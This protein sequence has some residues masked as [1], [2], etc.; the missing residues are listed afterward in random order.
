MDQRHLHSAS[1]FN[2]RLPHA[3]S[4]APSSHHHPLVS[5]PTHQQYLQP[6]Q[7][8]RPY[9][10]SQDQVRIPNYQHWSHNHPQRSNAMIGS[11]TQRSAPAMGIGNYNNRNHLSVPLLP[12]ED[13]ISLDDQPVIPSC[14][15]MPFQ[16]MQ[17]LPQPLN[18][19]GRPAVIGQYTTPSYLDNVQ[20]GGNLQCRMDNT[21]HH[22]RQPQIL[23]QYG[24]FGSTPGYQNPGMKQAGAYHNFVFPQQTNNSGYIG[25]QTPHFPVPFQQAPRPRGLFNF[26]TPADDT[27]RPV[28]NLGPFQHGMVNNRSG[29]ASCTSNIRSNTLAQNTG[30]RVNLP[31]NAKPF[32]VFEKEGASKTVSIPVVPVA[33]SPGTKTAVDAGQIKQV[34]NPVVPPIKLETNPQHSA[35]ERI[36]KQQIAKV[37]SLPTCPWSQLEQRKGKLGH[38][39]VT[40]KRS[41]KNRQANSWSRNVPTVRNNPPKDSGKLPEKIPPHNV[42]A[43]SQTAKRIIRKVLFNDRAG[44]VKQG[45]D[46][47]VARNKSP[48]IV[49]SQAPD[50]E[51]LQSNKD[52]TVSDR[53]YST[54]KLQP[55]IEMPLAS[56]KISPNP[57][58]RLLSFDELCRSSSNTVEQAPHPSIS[59]MT[60]AGKD[61]PLT[62]NELMQ[63]R[64]DAASKSSNSTTLG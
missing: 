17:S 62:L 51:E 4:Q 53:N 37:V 27:S 32:V 7:T 36:I 43:Q 6:H 16:R 58:K 29:S 63:L 52:E 5:F 25:S 61:R 20:G 34:A 26:P 11:G 8:S 15:S 40:R 14:N 1:A 64:D 28:T 60:E 49:E 22:T 3:Y 33:P 54:P 2:N 59:S 31:R 13:L 10:S 21:I 48:E 23:P 30:P 44:E 47:D 55:E 38:N 50:K 9:L 45:P 19:V 42:V 12:G 35:R 57:G 56:S 18:T 24:P 41:P 39:A 46:K